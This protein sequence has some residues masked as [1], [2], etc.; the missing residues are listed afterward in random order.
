[1][2]EGRSYAKQSDTLAIL[3]KYFQ[4]KYRFYQNTMLVHCYWNAMQEKKIG[5]LQSTSVTYD[6]D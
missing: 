4:R 1:M 5:M 6:I 3:I 2:K